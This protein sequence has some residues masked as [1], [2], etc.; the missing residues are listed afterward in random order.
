MATNDFQNR[1]D[2][3]LNPVFHNPFPD[4]FVLKFLNE[5]WAYCTGFW[6][7]GGCFGILHSRNLVDWK[8]QGSALNPMPFDAT[9]YW[10]PEVFY[11]NGRFFMYYSVGNETMMEIRVAIADHPAGPFVD[12]GRKLTSED[13]AID[14]HVFVDSDGARYLFYATDFLEHTQIGTGTVVDRM[15]DE[16]T[17]EGNPQPVTRARFDWQVYDPQRKEKG[18]VRWHTVEGPFVLKRKGIY[19]EMFSGGNWQN[20]TYGVSYATSKQILKDEEWEQASDGVRVLP[21][22]RTL[23]GKIVGPGHNS[24]VRGPDNRELYCVYHRWAEDFGG[25]M[26]SID[27]LDWAGERLFIAGPSAAPQPAPILPTFADYFDEEQRSDL[28]ENWECEG[29]SWFARDGSA[30]QEL[31]ASATA[32]CKIKSPCFVAEV[33]FRSTEVSFAATSAYGVSLSDSQGEFVSFLISPA[34]KQAIISYRDEEGWSSEIFPLPEKFEPQAFHLLR[35][36]NEYCSINIVFDNELIRWKKLLKCSCDT[37][38]LITQHIA[39]AFS[40]FALTIGWEDLFDDENIDLSFHGWQSNELDARWSVVD[41]EL[42]CNGE[43]GFSMITKGPQLNSYEMIVNARLINV[44]ADCSYGFYPAFRPDNP[45]P[46]VTVERESEKWMLKVQSQMISEFFPLPGNFD[47]TIHQQ[48]R[49]RKEIG[50]I[51]IQHEATL[52]GEIEGVTE[53]TQIG[54]YTLGGETAFDMVRVTCLK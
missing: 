21:I 46:L 44:S 23:P 42:R 36:E 10:A 7:D 1:S 30:I 11:E 25:R 52:L 17:L 48:F 37:I 28:G 53:P 26:M 6:R 2:K 31:N 13:F 33:S 34:R 12:S 43:D 4:P 51:Q 16:F 19:Y 24:V 20:I 22:L 45:G 14:P 49:F 54:L 3:Y 41:Q 50:R 39:A 35:M 38:S 32:R 8:E 27:P 15:L 18:G 5:Y 9:C 47:A 40:G 29:G